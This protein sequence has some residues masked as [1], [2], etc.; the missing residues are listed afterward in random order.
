MLLAGALVLAAGLSQ[1]APSPAGQITVVSDPAGSLVRVHFS[2]PR[3]S[4]EAKLWARRGSDSNY[5]LVCAAP[6]KADI[7]AGTPLRATITDHE[8]EPYDF[9]LSNEQAREVD[10]VARRGGRG[11]LAGGIVMT[12][13]GGLGVLVGIIF[14]AFSFGAFPGGNESALR[15]A[16]LISLGIGGALAV[17][18]VAIIVTRSYEPVVKQDSWENRRSGMEPNRWATVPV[19]AATTPFSLTVSF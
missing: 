10:I 14:T 7:P 3:N 9:T 2:T 19:P 13:V 5:T 8:D 4:L 16:G 18:G 17:G 12:S 1:A 15:T 11:A 6:C